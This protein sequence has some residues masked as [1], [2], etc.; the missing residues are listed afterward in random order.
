MRKPA[1]AIAAAA[2]VVTLACA[3]WLILAQLRPGGWVFS[4]SEDGVQVYWLP[5]TSAPDGPALF[6][7][8][9]NQEDGVVWFNSQALGGDAV[10]KRTAQRRQL[11]LVLQGDGLKVTLEGYVS[12]APEGATAAWEELRT[13]DL[14]RLVSAPDFTVTGPG[15]VLNGN[16][17]SALTDFAVACP[18][19]AEP[20]AD[21]L[22]WG[23]V[24]SLAN[25]YSLDV[26]RR[27]FRIVRGDRFGRTYESESGATL[28]VMAGVNALQQSLESA[29]RQGTAGLPDFDRETYRRISR[30]SAVVS[31]MSGD[32]IVYYK[33]R[34]TCGGANFA[35]FVLVYAPAERGIYDAVATRMS[36]SF[37]R[38]T[39]PDGRPLCP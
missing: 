38:A 30:D 20:A 35:S 19:V 1:L 22:G 14:A 7:M 11:D 9:C 36:R 13:A 33:A 28:T 23:T 16:G 17:A 37:D 5:R 39:L 25:G 27:L 4:Q 29:I 18:P 8:V 31:G 21:A 2:S 10:E 24:S 26:P 34:A 3:A 32:S 15:F 12:A 6:R